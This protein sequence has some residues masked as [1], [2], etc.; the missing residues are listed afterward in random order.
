MV[1]FPGALAAE[2]CGGRI[3]ASMPPPAGSG[4]GG[5]GEHRSLSELTTA[6][7]ASHSPPS[8]KIVSPV[9]IAPCGTVAGMADPPG[10]T[11]GAPGSVV[12]SSPLPAWCDAWVAMLLDPAACV[13]AAAAG[14]PSTAAK[15]A[16]VAAATH[17]APRASVTLAMRTP[18]DRCPVASTLAGS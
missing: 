8:P 12:G 1:S 6:D 9:Q 13:A 15:T 14:T 4:E 17:A 5:P 7:P 2:V 11:P 16:S 18:V 3:I 10:F